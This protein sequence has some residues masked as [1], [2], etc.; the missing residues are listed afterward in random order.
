MIRRFLVFATLV[1]PLF[2]ADEWGPAQFLIGRWTGEGGG[3]P[4]QGSGS[5]SFT[6]D[7]QGKILIRKN[8]SEYPPA[9]GKLA[10]RHDDLTILYRESGQL[11]ALYFDSEEHVIPYV[12]KPA[13]GGVVFVTEAPK[14]APRYRLTYTSTGSDT[15][16]IK[17]EVAPPCKDFA[18]YIEASA[19]RDK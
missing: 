6:P 15:L 12:V 17:F 8:F 2:A 9:N 7:L 10:F 11:K 4:G 3:G 18:T 1:L 13:E 16:K 19:H 14:T 5:F